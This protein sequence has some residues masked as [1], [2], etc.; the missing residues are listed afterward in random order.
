M[1]TLVIAK[2]EIA[3]FFVSPLAYLVGVAFLFITGLVFVFTTVVDN[4]ATLI[5]VFQIIGVVLLFMAP[6]LTMRLLSQ[7]ARLG[8]LELLLTTPVRDW[9]VVLGKFLAAFFFLATLLLPTFYYLF[10]LTQFGHPDIPATMSGYVGVILLGAT[11]LSFGM[12]TSAISG[13]Q[14]A[15]AGSG[16]VLSLA[17]WLVGGLAN[18]FQGSPGNLLAYLSPRDHFFDFIRGLITSANII[19]FLSATAAALFLATRVLEVRRY[20]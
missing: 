4:V 20:R 12:L 3:A 7:E 11:L 2:R 1:N 18:I 14:I 15:A 10:L 5:P 6:I 17:F 8:T 16:V 13:N 9:E 19:Y